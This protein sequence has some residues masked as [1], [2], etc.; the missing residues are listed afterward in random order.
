MCIGT[1]PELLRYSAVGVDPGPSPCVCTVLQCYSQP[2]VGVL[3]VL[4]ECRLLTVLRVGISTVPLPLMVLE[5][6]KILGVC[7]GMYHHN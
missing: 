7:F 4:K 5:E 6:C 1:S 3:M 2:L